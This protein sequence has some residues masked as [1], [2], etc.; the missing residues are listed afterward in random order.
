MPLNVYDLA[1]LKGAKEDE[2]GR[3][4]AQ[5]FYDLGLPFFAGCQGC[6]ASLGPGQ[7]YPSRTGYIQCE[8]CI[9]DRG[10]ETVEAFDQF[11]KE[12]N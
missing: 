9:G 1:I 5:V 4:S 6:G 8:D 11:C 7:S 2:N 12:D 10:F 3:M